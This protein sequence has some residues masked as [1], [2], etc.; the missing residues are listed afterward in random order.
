M[1]MNC[2]RAF[3]LKAYHGNDS[4]WYLYLGWNRDSGRDVVQYSG[5]SER[6][7][8]LGKVSGANW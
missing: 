8:L 7:P 1:R 5:E 6:K 2:R 4:S 3:A